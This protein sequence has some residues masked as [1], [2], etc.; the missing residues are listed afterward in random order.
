[1]PTN[2]DRSAAMRAKLIDAGRALFAEKGFADTSTPDIARAA[3][4]T[5]GA[6]Y[7][8][9]ADKTDLMRAVVEQEAEVVARDIHRSGQAT[10]DAHGAL[11]A[12]AK[13]Y[14]TA[15]QVPG[16][17]RLL[18]LE[19]PSALGV[20]EM[21]RIDRETGGQTLVDGL[22]DAMP[23]HNTTALPLE[24][25]ANVLSAA[26]D[27]AAMAIADGADAAGYEDAIAMLLSWLTGGA[28]KR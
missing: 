20:A 2:R 5:R 25:L 12:G 6:M 13:A 15:M 18:L 26:F 22:A 16:R 27:R 11:M 7:H 10:D 14:F 19:G 21:Q 23:E 8:H 17:V 24:E 9:F 3:G 28:P 4:V 1:M